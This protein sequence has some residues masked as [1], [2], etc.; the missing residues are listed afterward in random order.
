MSSLEAGPRPVQISPLIKFS[1]WS[2][3]LA[4]I[5]Y[6]SFH[7]NRLSKKE[8]ARREL[9]LKEKPKRDAEAAEKK[10]RLYEAEIK[11]LSETLN[12]VVK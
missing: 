3:L 9:E 8:N 12:T 6:G 7:Q 11:M 1:R 4:G 2:L 5:L 10:K